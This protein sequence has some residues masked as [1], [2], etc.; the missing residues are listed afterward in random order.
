MKVDILAIGAH[1]DDVELGCAGTLLKHIHKG[2][3]AAVLDLTRGE[4]GT[5]GNPEL[6]LQE[7]AT[8]AKILGI[9]NRSNAGFKDGFFQND[10]AHR[11]ELIRYIRFYQPAVVLAN[12][13][14]DRHPDHGMAA[15]LVNDAIFLSGL[16]KIETFWNGEKQKAH[17]PKNCYHYVQAR[18]V[19]VQ[20]VVDITDFMET[21]VAAIM[22]YQSQFHNPDSAEPDTFIS[23]PEFMEFVKAR[24]SHFGV[25]AGYRYAEGFSASHYMGIPDLLKID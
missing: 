17:R 16:P 21:K 4:L 11:L 15:R 2:Y 24:A 7:S 12:A 9:A 14:S 19:P 3:T 20:L 18:E 23:S 10:E 8:A 22:A 25:P 1:P 6:R 5:R 13:L